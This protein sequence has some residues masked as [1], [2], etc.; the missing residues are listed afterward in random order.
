MC[1]RRTMTAA[2]LAPLL[3]LGLGG[4]AGSGS[5]GDS[6]AHVGS[7]AIEQVGGRPD[8]ASIGPTYGHGAIT[9]EP[10]G[11]LEDQVVATWV[12]ETVDNRWIGQGPSGACGNSW[13]MDLQILEQK[14]SGKLWLAE[15]EYDLYGR[16]GPDG[17]M[18]RA[19]AGKT[20]SNAHRPGPRFLEINLLFQGAKADGDYAVAAYD[21]R[22]CATHVTLT[23]L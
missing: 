21:R 17:K 12:S 16:L 4:C 6:A 7:G 5:D 14:V 13:A 11:D 10:L 23:K 18:Q 2:A 15:V 3:A 20:P 9:V 1:I 22:M 8:A 19:R